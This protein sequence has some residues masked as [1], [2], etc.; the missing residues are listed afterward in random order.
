MFT[1][2]PFPRRF[3]A[4]A[5]AGFNAVEFLFPY[6][7]P[8]QDVGAVAR[9]QPASRTCCSICR[10]ETGRQASVAARRFPDA[11]P[12]SSRAS[13]ARSSM[14]TPRH[15]EPSRHG[16]YP[17]RRRG[18]GPAPRGLRQQPEGWRPSA[19][20]AHGRTLLIEAINPRDIP[21]FFLNT[22]AEAHAIR[23][24]VG[25]TADLKVQMD[26]YHAQIVERRPG[27]DV[28]KVLRRHR[29]RADCRRAGAR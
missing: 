27:D 24:E 12:S 22:Q 28:Q 5:R 19:R 3:E 21:G 26:F 20:H 17:A 1:E 14:P 11:R 2:L 9:G 8:A 4:A 18:S 10:Q 13:T 6:D 7:F 25:R 23:E 29:P 15:S 16:G